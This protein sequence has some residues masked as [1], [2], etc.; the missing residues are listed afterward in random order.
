M[1]NDSVK[2]PIAAVA[3]SDLGS[4]TGNRNLGS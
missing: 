1:D 3:K 2:M 4:P